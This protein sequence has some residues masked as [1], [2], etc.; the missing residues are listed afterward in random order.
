MQPPET[1]QVQGPNERQYPDEVGPGK[2]EQD[3][4]HKR[5]DADGIILIL[6]ADSFQFQVAILSMATV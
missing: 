3:E 1:I 2:I 6:H 5:T 4:E